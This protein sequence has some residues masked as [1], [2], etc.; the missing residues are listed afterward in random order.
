MSLYKSVGSYLAQQARTILSLG[1]VDEEWTAQ[2]E[3]HLG[4]SMLEDCEAEPFMMRWPVAT[5]STVSNSAS[6]GTALLNKE[7]S[8]SAAT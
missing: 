3:I 7:N 2:G 1:L 8:Q 4:R 5:R 6:D